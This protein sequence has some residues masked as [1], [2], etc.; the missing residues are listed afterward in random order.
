[1]GKGLKFLSILTGSSESQLLNAK[2]EVKRAFG[3]QELSNDSERDFVLNKIIKEME[4]LDYAKIRELKISMPELTAMVID[5]I[6]VKKT[7]KEFMY[8]FNRVLVD[9]YEYKLGNAESLN[10]AIN[11]LAYD[12]GKKVINL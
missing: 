5:E 6:S 7:N 12:I 3:S 9:Y 1:M 2:A 10:K 11:L 4:K 8:I